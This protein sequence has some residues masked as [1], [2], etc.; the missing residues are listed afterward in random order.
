MKS[1]FAYKWHAHT[2]THSCSYTKFLTVLFASEASFHKLAACSW[3]LGRLFTPFHAV[4]NLTADLHYK[5]VY[6][7]TLVFVFKWASYARYD[8][9]LSHAWQHAPALPQNILQQLHAPS[10]WLSTHSLMRALLGALY[11]CVC[12]CVCVVVYV[13]FWMGGHVVKSGV[14]V[15]GQVLAVELFAKLCMANVH[16]GKGN[17]YFPFPICICNNYNRLCIINTSIST[18]LLPV[19]KWK[20]IAVDEMLE[21]ICTRFVDFFSFLF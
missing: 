8:L 15:H 13:H 6:E 12:L 20:L 2:H 4:M 1:A 19:D 17:A 5:F 11:A 7:F 18:F 3:K 9:R 21:Y 14:K 10:D 16:M